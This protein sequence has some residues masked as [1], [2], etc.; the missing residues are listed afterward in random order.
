MHTYISHATLVN[1]CYKYWKAKKLGYQKSHSFCEL[2][3][4]DG[5]R[6]AIGA[7]MDPKIHGDIEDDTVY[8]LVNDEYVIFENAGF[9]ATLQ[10]AHDVC[11]TTTMSIQRDECIDK[12]ER[13]L[14][15]AHAELNPFTPD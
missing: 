11:C 1:A 13:L 3:Y 5:A 4:K 6:C 15:Q 12:F 14:K 7:A 9:A 10:K 8:E 2:F